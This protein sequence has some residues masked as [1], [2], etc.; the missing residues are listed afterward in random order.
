MTFD[1]VLLRQIED[2][3]LARPVLWPDAAVHGDTEQEA[4][5]GVRDLIH[6]L[7]GRTQFVKVDVDTAG[8]AAK[9]PWLDKAGMFSEDPTWDDF[10][11]EMADYRRQLNEAVVAE[12]P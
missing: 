6:D 7:L 4:L 1:V 2:G 9:N 3:Y 12:L 11:A 8:Y 10:L 5:D